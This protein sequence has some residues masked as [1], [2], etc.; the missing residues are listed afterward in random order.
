MVKVLNIQTP[1]TQT[2][3]YTILGKNNKHKP[4]LYNNIRDFIQ[5]KGINT[6]FEMGK[7]RIVMSTQSKK[8]GTI[9]T[10]SLKLMG[11]VR[12]PSIKK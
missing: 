11:I 10:K 7:D 6:T 3:N 2:Y 8:I 9:I 4:Y 1:K 5:G 12:E